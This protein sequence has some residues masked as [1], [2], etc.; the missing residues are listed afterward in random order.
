MFIQI[1]MNYFLESIKI[2]KN[3]LGEGKHVIFLYN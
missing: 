3:N 2:K 1:L